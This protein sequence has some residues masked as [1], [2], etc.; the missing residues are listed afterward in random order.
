MFEWRRRVVR[1]GKGVRGGR[2]L[3]ALKERSRVMSTGWEIGGRGG[4]VW[5]ELW[6]RLRVWRLGY[7]RR[8][9]GERRERLQ[10]VRLRV[11]DGS[12]GGRAT[13]WL[14]VEMAE[15]ERVRGPDEG[16]E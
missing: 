13:V 10:R 9:G 7:G 1:V 6:E 14:V 2:Y 15:K 16:A 11:C 8:R 12:A 3:R 5:R 4:K